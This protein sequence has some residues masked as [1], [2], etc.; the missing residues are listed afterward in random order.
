M[1]ENQPWIRSYIAPGGIGWVIA[2]LVLFLCV[3]AYFFPV[4]KVP[5]F[6]LFLIGALAVAR[7]T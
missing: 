4:V 3:A 6:E 5:P 1:P 2:L 7:L